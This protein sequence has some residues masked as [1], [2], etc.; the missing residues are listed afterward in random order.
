VY[1]DGDKKSAAAALGISLNT[2]YNRLNSYQRSK[3]A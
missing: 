3:S 1:F 2:L